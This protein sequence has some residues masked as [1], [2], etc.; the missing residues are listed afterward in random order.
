MKPPRYKVGTVD[1][2]DN[3]CQNSENV[4][5]HYAFSI[6]SSETKNSFANFT[7]GGLQVKLLVA[8]ERL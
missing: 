5:E 7:V 4:E 3:V 6:T 8:L 2:N 1:M